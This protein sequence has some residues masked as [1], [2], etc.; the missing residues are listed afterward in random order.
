M[1]ASRPKN[2]PQRTNFVPISVIPL[3]FYQPDIGTETSA[4]TA[5]ASIN[6]LLASLTMNVRFIATPFFRAAFVTVL[7]TFTIITAPCQTPPAASAHDPRISQILESLEQVHTIQQT[8]L[9]PDGNFIAWSAGG[10]EVAPLND[11]S[12]PRAIT[13]CTGEARGRDGGFDWS[14]D[15][16]QLAFFS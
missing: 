8:D 7:S 9:S 11:P 3:Q 5:P 14:P 13:A 1:L 15:S 10:I 6:H 2:F 12:H 4:R 16:K